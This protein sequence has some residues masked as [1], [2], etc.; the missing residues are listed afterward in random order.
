M[1]LIAEEISASLL[2]HGFA[3]VAIETVLSPAWSTDWLSDSAKLKLKRY[4]IAPP[5]QCASKQCSISRHTEDPVVPCPRCDST[6]TVRVSQFG[7]T[8]CKA[9]YRCTACHEPFDYFK[10]H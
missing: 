10:A 6:N 1:E 3:E 7:S 8:A 2:R 4:G 5:T 9:T